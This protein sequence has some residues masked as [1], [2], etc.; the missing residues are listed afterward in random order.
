MRHPDGGPAFPEH[1][2]IADHPCVSGMKLRDWFAGM[3][4]QGC[5]ASAIQVQ[6]MAGD[7]LRTHFAT[8]AYQYA[9][10]M[11]KARDT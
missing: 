1:C 4:L 2:P 9:D 5:L 6:V 7:N 8:I 11:L 10:A 3:A